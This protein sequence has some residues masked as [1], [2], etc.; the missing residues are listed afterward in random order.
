[1]ALTQASIG[2][3]DTSA[4]SGLPFRN[5]IING[6]MR[7]SQRNGTSSATPASNEY[8]LDRW[9]ANVGGGQYTVQQNAGSVTPP[10]GFTNYFGVTSTGVN[11]ASNFA[12][13][14]S[15][16]GYNIADLAWGGASA[17]PV[18]LSFWVRSS[19]T[20]TF[21]GSI[22]NGA[23]DRSYV[24]TYTISAANT[25]Q[26]VAVTIAGDT[27]GTWTADNSIGM[28]VWFSMGTASGQ[29]TATTNAWIAGDYRAVTSTTNI[30]GTNGATFYIT[31]VQLEAGS[32]ATA[33][34]R[35]PYTTELQLCQRYYEKTYLQSEVPGANFD[36][37]DSASRTY[38]FGDSSAQSQPFVWNFKVSKR[39]APT[40][41]IYNPFNGTANQYRVLETGTNMSAQVI[42]NL[43]TETCTVASA[44]AGLSSNYRFDVHITAASEL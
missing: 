22:K 9:Q 17:K 3:I 39:G 23:F 21:S 34:E 31:G 10:A 26:Q 32:Q 28:I 1:M 2:I 6:D 20:G 33:F 16:E 27:T 13:R 30:M 37:R 14:Q 19:L 15:I 18:T 4:A 35:R 5:R 24:F 8:N 38:S 43:S 41:N 40:V 11:A 12:I 42:K 36:A 29:G 44:G 7:I 25:W